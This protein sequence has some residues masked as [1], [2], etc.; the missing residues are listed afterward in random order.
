MQRRY[1]LSSTLVRKVGREGSHAEVN[2]R[3]KNTMTRISKI[4]VVSSMLAALALSANAAIAKG[5]SHGGGS[6]AGSAVTGT[7][8]SAGK[9]KFNEFTIKKKQP[10]RHLQNSFRMRLKE[11]TIRKLQLYRERPGAEKVVQATTIP[12]SR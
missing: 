8:N 6:S 11:H 7:T 9:A 3:E 10:T 1:L 2:G 4:Y 5:G 12:K